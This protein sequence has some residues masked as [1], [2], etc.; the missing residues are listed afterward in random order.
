[1]YIYVVHAFQHARICTHML[2]CRM[3]GGGLDDHKYNHMNIKFIAVHAIL[4]C[5]IRLPRREPSKV[6]CD[7]VH[8]SEEP[9]WAEWLSFYIYHRATTYVLHILCSTEK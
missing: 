8:H 4:F 2:M 5:F 7:S 6:T 9:P 3:V 1:M